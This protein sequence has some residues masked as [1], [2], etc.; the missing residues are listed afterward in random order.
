MTKSTIQDYEQ[1]LCISY[2]D[3]V[4]AFKGCEYYLK[5][6]V[7]STVLKAIYISSIE[8]EWKAFRDYLNIF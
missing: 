5:A 7:S 6:M 4:E 2:L 3:E 1:R 8:A